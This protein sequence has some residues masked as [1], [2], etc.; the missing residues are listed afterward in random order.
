MRALAAT[1]G[2][3]LGLALAG[4]AALAAPRCPGPAPTVRTLLRGQGVLESVIV[5]RRGPLYFTGG[6]SVLRLDRPGAQP[7]VLA[8]I[9]DPGGLA[10]D[11]DGALLVGS[12][13]TLANGSMGDVTG[14]SSLVRVDTETGAQRTYATG[15]SMGN[16]LVRGP[17]GSFYASND[18]GSNIDRIRNG[19]TERGWARVESG[20]GLA[21]DRAGRYL[22]AAQT[23]RPAAVSRVELATART[24]EY[25]R[26]DPAD[27]A[28]GLDGMDR[29]EADRLFVAANGAGEVWRIDPPGRICLLL[30]DLAP[31]PNGPSAVAVGRGDGP[32]PQGNLYVVA[33]GGD[34]LELVGVAATAPPAG[35]ATDLRCLSRRRFAI[36]VR[37]GRRA[38][39]VRR[40]RMTIDGRRVPVRVGR[41][42]GGRVRVVVDLRG[43][44]GGRVRVR[45][46]LRVRGRTVRDARAYR[47]CAPPRA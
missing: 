42:R 22:Y 13:N 39:R 11:G 8:P 29:D 28:A 33:F 43:R 17:D 37:V 9:P 32:F 3:V 23:F 20:N 40:A 26:A 10:F 16:G 12:G 4:E 24:S 2:L 31:F 44:P 36:H 46:T 30:D 45:V 25:V 5:D 27:I 6:D 18:G 7:R 35:G 34:V 19:R 38:G 21:I 14:P 41:A 1:A 47:T 15:L